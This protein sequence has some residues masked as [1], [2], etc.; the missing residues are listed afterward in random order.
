MKVLNLIRIREAL[1]QVLKS[2]KKRIDFKNLGYLPRWLILCFDMFICCVAL[3]ITSLIVKNI[4]ISDLNTSTS[5]T[6]LGLAP[7]AGLILITNLLFFIFFRTYAGLIRHSTFIDAIKFFLASLATLITLLVV[8]YSHLI[9]NGDPL[10]MTPKLFIYFVMSFS[11]LL[12][13]RV[14]VKQVFEAY[15]DYATKEERINVIIYG[16]D[17]NAIAI[18]NALKVERPVRYKL[19]GFIDKRGKNQ[20]KEILGLPIIHYKRKLSV[21]MR[22]YGANAIILADQSIKQEERI[23]IVDECLEHN[24]KVLRAPIVADMED[25]ANVNLAQQIQNVQIEDLLEREPIV[26]NN[27]LIAKELYNRRI[28]VTGGAG[29]IGSEIARQVANYKPEKLIIVDQAETPLYQIQMEIKASFPDLNFEAVIADVRDKEKLDNIFSTYKPQVVYHAAAYKHVPLMEDNPSQAIFVNVMGTK[30]VA[31]TALKHKVD[32]FVLV[33]TDKA[34]NPS[35]VMGASKRIAEIYVQT[36]QEAFKKDT[37][38]VTNYVTTR[39]GNVL[40]SNGSVVPLFKR[41]IAEGGPLTIT[42]PD[43]IRYFMTIPEACQLVLEAGAMGNGGEIYI[44][45]MGEA[46]KIIDLAKKIIKLAGFIPNKDIDIKIIGLRPGEKL[47]EELLNDK[48]TT[49]PTYNEKIM[50]ARAEMYDYEVINKNIADLI[51]SASLFDKVEVVKR[52]KLLVPEYKSMNSTY[53]ELDKKE[54]DTK[55]DLKDKK[56]S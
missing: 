55:T 43:I 13:F 45:D 14:L 10:F 27:K 11:F 21:I 26:L 2:S 16:I 34:V 18:S 37:R 54:K 19:I 5:E 17:A 7:R 28:L 56:V 35:N 6:F 20:S 8:N 51:Q 40:G 9:I 12:L 33:S 52:M 30:N 4:V 53:E 1:K 32:K 48:S 44:F 38:Y 42:H 47:Y 46:V 49:L 3:L 50:I 31:D 23:K 41:Q 25:K 29:S 15:F 22:A 24:L 36:L 39:F